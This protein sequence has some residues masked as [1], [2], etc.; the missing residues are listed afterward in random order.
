MN[1]NVIIAVVVIAVVV[2]ALPIGLSVMKK[3]Q[4]EGAASGPATS[5]GSATTAPAAPA[6]V[7]GLTAA[8]LSG[9]Q[10]NVTIP[11]IPLP[12]KIALNSGGQA[13]ATI[14]NPTVQDLIRKENNGIYPVQ[15]QWSVSGDK[16]KV[17]VTVKG[18][19]RG[20]DADIRGQKLFF[21]GKEIPRVK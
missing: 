20:I 7:P 11:D 12:I 16:L 13:V 10:W 8:T 17:S 14:D 15:G 2:I 5:S 4:Q 19:S 3:G 18:Q 1:K 21:Q 6:G 9:S